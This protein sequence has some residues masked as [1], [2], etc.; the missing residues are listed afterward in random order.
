MLQIGTLLGKT[1]RQPL[2][3]FRYQA[4]RSF[5]CTARFV[6]KTG[7]YLAPAIAEIVVCSIVEERFEVG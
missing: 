4:V 2:H 3:Q 1:L 6:D 5:H 7:L